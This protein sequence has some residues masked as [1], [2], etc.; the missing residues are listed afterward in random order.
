V[1]AVCS[2]PVSIVPVSSEQDK[3]VSFLN[4][5]EANKDIKSKFFKKFDLGR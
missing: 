5:L 3:L 2:P 4:T 1:P